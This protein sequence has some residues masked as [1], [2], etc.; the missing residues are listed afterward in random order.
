MMRNVR[1]TI[2]RLMG[3]VLVMGLGSVALR[4]SS[5][6]WAGVMLLMTGGVLMVALVGAACRGPGER[7]WWLGFALSGCGYLAIA[8]WTPTDNRPLPTIALVDWLAPKLEILAAT[9][10]RP[11][12]EGW[13][14]LSP[15]VRILHGLWSQAAGLV[16]CLVAGVFAGVG[17]RWRRR[18]DRIAGPRCPGGSA[19]P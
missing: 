9:T 6:T 12:A 10:T 5:E 13:W 8:H 1:F 15:A 7:A 11:G 14:S 19:R 16:G 17:G 2:A 18:R 3:L 4:F